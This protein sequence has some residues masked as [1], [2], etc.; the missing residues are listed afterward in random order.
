MELINGSYKALEKEF[1]TYF[2]SV[3]TKPLEKILIIT[4]SERLTQNLK[5]KLLSSKEC[6][7]CVFWQDILGLVSSINQASAAY[8][9]LKEPTS[10]DYFKLKDFL[11]RHNF[12]TSPGYIQALESSFRDMQNALIMPQDLKKI[13]EFDPSLSSKELKDL[14]F[15]YHNYLNLSVQPGRVS[16][17]D[18]FVSALGNIENNTYLAQFK[19]IIF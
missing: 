19:Q 12:N 6:L 5:A 18:F 9:P 17:K 13:E 2:S 10:L 16:Y 4:Q 1:L 14:I 15:I 7:S 8:I 3:K 11:E